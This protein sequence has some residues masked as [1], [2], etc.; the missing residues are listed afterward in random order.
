MNGK[1]ESADL[2]ARARLALLAV[3]HWNYRDWDDVAPFVTGPLAALLRANRTETPEPPDKELVSLSFS[4]TVLIEEDL[5]QTAA[6]YLWRR[7]DEEPRAERIV[8]RF[9]LEEG[10]WKA[11]AFSRQNSQAAGRLSP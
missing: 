10:R 4:E 7:G 5:F 1:S 11:A 8:W 6:D 9:L 3:W 2:E